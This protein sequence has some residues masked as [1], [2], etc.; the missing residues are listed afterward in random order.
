V[1]AETVEGSSDFVHATLPGTDLAHEE[2][3][4][5]AHL[6][7]PGARDNASGCCTSL[8][9]VR[10]LGKLTREGKLPPLRRTIRFMHGV[11]VN[12]F[13]PYI[14]ANRERLPQ[15]VAGL[16]ADSLAQDFT[17]CGGEMVLFLSPEHNASFIDGLVQMLLCAV[18]AEPARRFTTANNAT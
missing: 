16:C 10:T 2:I 15:V 1:Q 18:A 14:D 7:E 11:E 9:L 12:G 4:V 17:R 5:L 8:E 3:W 13:L 6:S